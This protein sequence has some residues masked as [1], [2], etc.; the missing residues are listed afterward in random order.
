MTSGSFLRQLRKNKN[1]SLRQLSIKSGVSH[2]QIADVEKG[3]NYGTKEKL[4]K[5]LLGLS[6]KE[7]EINQFYEMQDY[8]K[9]PESIKKKLSTFQIKLDECE[10]QLNIQNN[11]NN[12]HIIVGNKNTIK[13]S[14][15]GTEL[16]K[17]L[18]E[19]SEKEKEKVLKFINEYIK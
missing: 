6:L 1:F 9:S 12:G 18:N 16:G 2:T 13:N 5:I 7:E 14:Y 4:D 3:I 15:A 10:Y 11:S 8:E 19:L 17:E